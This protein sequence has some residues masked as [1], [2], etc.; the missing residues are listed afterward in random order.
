MHSLITDILFIPPILLA[1]TVHEYFHGYIALRMGDPT[2]KFAGRLTFNPIKHIDIFGLIAFV[3]FRFGWAKPVPIQPHNFRDL[4]KGILYSSL[5]GP[6]SNFVLA[7]LFGLIL[8][9][10]PTNI[11]VLMP[12]HAMLGGGLILNLI[13]CAF[14][15]IP[16]PPLDGS[17]VLFSLLPP[18]YE[19]IKHWLERYG[20]ILLIGLISFDRITGI[21]ILWGWI[22]PF[23][24]LFG[25]L[26]AGSA[27]FWTFITKFF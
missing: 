1:L 12:I 19:Y 14:N 16:I 20:F 25:Q 21:P 4:K 2:A 6:T 9:V 8:R 5:A 10:F 23:V 11:N 24:R 3:L 15:L 13:F 17:H 18:G 27:A 7:I 26:F 22:W